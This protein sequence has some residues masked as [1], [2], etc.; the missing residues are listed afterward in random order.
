MFSVFK[1]P[2]SRLVKF[3]HA[4]SAYCVYKD[5]YHCLKSGQVQRGGLEF[6][7]DYLEKISVDSYFKSSVVIHLSYA[8]GELLTNGDTGQADSVLAFI[9]DYRDHENFTAQG[10]KGCQL[11]LTTGLEFSK[12]DQMFQKVYRHL[13]AGDCYQLNLTHLF[14]FQLEQREDLNILNKFFTQREQL[15]AY[16]HASYLPEI[17][18]C[19]LSNSPECLFSIQGRNIYSMPIKGTAT[20]NASGLH[21]LSTS[22]KDQSELYMITDLIRNDLTKMSGRVAEVLIKK[23][24]LKVPQIVH[25]YSLVK[26]QLENSVN[27]SQVLAAIFPGGSITGAPKRRATE[28]LAEIE[29]ERRGFYCGSTLLFSSHYKQASINIR[30]AKVNYKQN[31]L[32]YGSG[33]GVTLLSKSEEEYAEM[34]LKLASFMDLI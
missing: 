29:Q 12:Y 24:V 17:D 16:A 1:L 8:F 30:T 33:G 15:S 3:S 5:S 21:A 31:E 9:L 34:M 4:N 20:Q 26:T 11:K 7:I 22:I 13:L 10:A 32:E 25:Q 23:G 18:T 2:L 6:L 19:L 14:K 28:L 27:M